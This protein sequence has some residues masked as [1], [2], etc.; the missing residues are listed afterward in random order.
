MS[1]TP[2]APLQ[3]V[4]TSRSAGPP[5]AT[6]R[7]DLHPQQLTDVTRPVLGERLRGVSA[8]THAVAFG[9][10]SRQLVVVSDDPVGQDSTSGVG[11]RSV[12]RICPVQG[13]PRAGPTSRI[14]GGRQAVPAWAPDAH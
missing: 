4:Q 7:L 3:P 1:S 12:T 10:R 13:A 5:P 8:G 14:D 11:A 9:S 6:E 2:S